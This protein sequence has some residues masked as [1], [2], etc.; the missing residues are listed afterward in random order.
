MRQILLIVAF[1]LA[2]SVAY[3]DYTVMYGWEDGTGTILGSDGNIVNVANVS[4]EHV[5][6]AGLPIFTFT[7]PGGTEGSRY[8]RA[9]ESPHEGLPSPYVYLVCITGLEA[10]DDVSATLWAYDEW[11]GYPPTVRIWAHY[12]T[13]QDCPSCPGEITGDAGGTPWDTEGTGWNSSDHTWSYAPPSAGD[14]L[15]I[16][17]RLNSSASPGPCD[18][19]LTDFFLDEVSVIVPDHASVMF[20]DYAGP[21]SVRESAWGGIKALYR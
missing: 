3:A 8:L 1:C 4:G 5:G 21:S 2:S 20:P 14:A 13:A 17:A 9:A 6:Q 10:G 15:V 18:S 7:V 11:L 19:C 16:K 12:S